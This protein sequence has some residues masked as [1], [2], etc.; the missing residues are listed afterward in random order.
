MRLR[1]EVL[2]HGLPTAKVLWNAEP[3]QTVSQLLEQIDDTFPLEA[4][5]WGFEDY[6]LQVAGYEVLHYMQ[7]GQLLKD[8]DQVTYVSKSSSNIKLH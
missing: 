2:R 5:G 4:D 1:V 7:L 6:A 8:D 3:E